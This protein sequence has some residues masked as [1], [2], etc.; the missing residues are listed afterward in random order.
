VALRL[1]AGAG[2]F[3]IGWP[4]G[5]VSRQAGPTR[6]KCSSSLRVE[7]ATFTKG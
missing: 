4:R 1:H 6:E 3:Y 2:L 7:T 5:I